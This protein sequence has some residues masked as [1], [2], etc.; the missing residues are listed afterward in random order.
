VSEAMKLIVDGLV[1]MNNRE[2]LLEMREHRQR[3]RNELQEKA[4]GAL[5][6]TKSLSTMDSDLSEVEEGLA[7][8]Q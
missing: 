1:K 2:K 3:L 4:G 7:R 8:L 6:L 5:D